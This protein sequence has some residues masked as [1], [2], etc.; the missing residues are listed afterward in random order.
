MLHTTT[1]SH[2]FTTATDILLQEFLRSDS[3]SIF[4]K[5]LY[6]RLRISSKLVFALQASF[7]TSIARTPFFYDRAKDV[8]IAL[9]EGN[10]KL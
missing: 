10:N 1:S 3:Y 2:K 6:E 5:Q 7:D 9:V 4:Y 8:H